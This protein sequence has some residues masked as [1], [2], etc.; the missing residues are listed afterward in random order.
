[1]EVPRQIWF[2]AC[3]DDVFKDPFK[4]G[5]GELFNKTADF[6]RDVLQRRRIQTFA[7]QAQVL[8]EGRTHCTAYLRGGYLISAFSHNIRNRIAYL[9]TGMCSVFSRKPHK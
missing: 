4:P 1:M 5:Y 7:L 8:A 6:L 2:T 9:I 3:T